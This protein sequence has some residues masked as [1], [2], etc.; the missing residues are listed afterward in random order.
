M[1]ENAEI[2][3]QKN[4]QK[5][6]LQYHTN[7]WKSSPRDAW[8]PKGTLGLRPSQEVPGTLQD[9]ILISFWTNL[10]SG[11]TEVRYNLR[12]MFYPES[13]QGD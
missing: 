13:S 7:P 6:N 4:R 11:F 10:G 5:G 1:F 2:A 3:K 12:Y 8:G 9:I